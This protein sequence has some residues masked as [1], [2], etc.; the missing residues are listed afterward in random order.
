[1]NK[2]QRNKLIVLLMLIIGIG[3]FIFILLNHSNVI[4]EYKPDSS[5]GHTGETTL[6]IR[7]SPI[8]FNRYA[9]QA[10]GRFD[11]SEYPRH[12]EQGNIT[13]THQ[14]TGQSFLFEYL[15]GDDYQSLEREYKIW[16]LPE[17]EYDIQWYCSDT[18]PDYELS[19][20]SLFY[21]GDRVD[22]LSG[23]FRIS[24]TFIISLAL[25]FFIVLGAIIFHF[26]IERR[27]KWNDYLSGIQQ[28]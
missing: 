11:I 9:I 26:M 23:R 27:Y 4:W 10:S 6:Y 17:G 25:A 21:P 24:M 7:S 14:G 19:A 8:H 20:A 12:R 22:L 1:M 28:K 16:V 18:I 13:F 3:Q 5:S 15:I 2:K